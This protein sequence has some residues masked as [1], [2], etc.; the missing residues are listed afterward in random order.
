MDQVTA[1]EGTIWVIMDGTDRN[2]QDRLLSVTVQFHIC[3]DT[4]AIFSSPPFLGNGL[5]SSSPYSNGNL[6]NNF[7]FFRSQPS[8]LFIFLLLFFA[9]SASPIFPL[10]STPIRFFLPVSTGQWVPVWNWSTGTW[11]KKNRPNRT[12]EE[13]MRLFFFMSLVLPGCVLIRIIIRHS[14]SWQ[15]IWKGGQKRRCKIKKDKKNIGKI[16][17]GSG[18]S[19]LTDWPSWLVLSWRRCA[20]CTKFMFPFTF[21]FPFLSR[22]YFLHNSVLPFAFRYRFLSAFM[23]Y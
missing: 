10:F 11:E 3:L 5:V 6:V 16:V 20:D 17:G 4:K 1:R 21:S 2:V 13:R 14:T 9:F 15:T 22:T 12:V 23:L 8:L 19:Q 18:S 7:F